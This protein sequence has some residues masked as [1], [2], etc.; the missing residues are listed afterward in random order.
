V[1]SRPDHRKRHE[2]AHSYSLTCGV[3]GQYF[4]RMDILA[5]HRAQHER[6]SH[7]WILQVGLLM[8]GQVS[9]LCK[10]FAASLACEHGHGLSKRQNANDDSVTV[11]IV[12]TRTYYKSPL[13]W[14]VQFLQSDW[15]ISQK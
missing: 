2:T 4:N 1:F 13:F 12:R 11:Y 9:L 8:P 6:P 10:F 14:L 3:W 7:R 5:R 15:L